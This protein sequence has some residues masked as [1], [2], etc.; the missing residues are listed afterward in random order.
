M[1]EHFVET[2]NSIPRA[3]RWYHWWPVL[4]FLAASVGVFYLANRTYST[5]TEGVTSGLLFGLSCFI[6]ALGG[7]W[8]RCWL[9]GIWL[10]VA[11]TGVTVVGF[12]AV[13]WEVIDGPQNYAGFFITPIFVL[14]ISLATLIARIIWGWQLEHPNS[15]SGQ[16]HVLGM[17]ET[18]LGVGVV[19]SF[20]ILLRVPQTVWE[21]P[22]SEFYS[23]VHQSWSFRVNCAGLDCLDLFHCFR[24]NRIQQ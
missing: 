4:V 20:L 6:A 2:D 14:G 22:V 7:L 9:R 13:T 21:M 12:M 1:A 15:T 16:H 3:G 23:R 24:S 11:I 17:E 19:A 10:A 8:S 18:L 5:W